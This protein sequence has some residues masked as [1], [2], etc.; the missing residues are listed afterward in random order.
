[1][2]TRIQAEKLEEEDYRGELFKDFDKVDAKGLKIC[3]KGN[4]DLLCLTK[5]QLMCD[6]HMEYFFVTANWHQTARVEQLTA[7]ELANFVA[8]CEQL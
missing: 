7:I 4:N 6:I 5:P 1:M 8:L 2:G 3:L